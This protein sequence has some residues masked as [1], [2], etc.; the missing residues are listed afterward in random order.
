VAEP[1]HFAPGTAIATSGSEYGHEFEQIMAVKHS[2]GRVIDSKFDFMQDHAS[3]LIRL[4][5][6][7]PT[8][9]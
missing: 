7:L 6:R 8:K 2:D 9:K 1:P 5:T 3:N 4:I